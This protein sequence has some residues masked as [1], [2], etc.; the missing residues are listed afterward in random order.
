MAGRRRFGC[1]RGGPLPATTLAGVDL[2]SSRLPLARR[3]ELTASGFTRIALAAVASLYVIVVTGGIV[4]LTSSGLGCESWPGC[5]AGA[6]FPAS[7]VHAFVEFGNRGVGLF[8][9]LL[10]LVTWLTGRRVRGLPRWAG[11][12]ALATCLGTLAQAPLGLLTIRFDLHPLLVMAHF[13]L[14][15][16]VL[17]GAIVVAVEALRLSHGAARPLVPREL[18]RAGLVLAGTCL[19]LVVTGAF[20]TAAGPHSGGAD[21]RRLGS[22][23]AS[24]W[25]HVRATALFGCVFLF[26]LGYLAARRDRSPRLFTLALALL[27]LLGAQMAV[28]ELQWRTEL[29][30]GLVSV[31]VA[32]AAAVWGAVVALVTILWRPLAALAPSR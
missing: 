7:D 18:R 16:L 20:T 5:E 11:R 3:F 32:L 23:D 9:I 27:A 19:A 24:L 1:T 25:V 6:F 2:Q 17:A 15:L 31:H 4:R 26:V 8:P 29:P 22:L 10:T 30:W 14:A 12:L 21:I 13:L 28:G